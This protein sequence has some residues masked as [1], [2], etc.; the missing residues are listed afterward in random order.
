VNVDSRRSGCRRR[1]NA[2]S[3]ACCDSSLYRIHATA[4]SSGHQSSSNRSALV[5][6]CSSA[7]DVSLVSGPL[8]ALL[9]H[10]VRSVADAIG[11]A[12]SN[13]A[14]VLPSDEAVR[15]PP[16]C[17]MIMRQIASP[18]P[19]PWDLVV[20]NAVK[21]RSNF[22]GSIP[23]PESYIATATAS[24]L[25]TCVVSRSTRFRSTV[26]SIASIAL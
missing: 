5:A 23:A 20:T 3:A 21:M 17:S 24:E 13:K 26:A 16:C 11:T 18:N 9:T 4:A 12:N 14:P 7:V 10:L 25:R 1:A 15:W 22:S 8:G 19:M 6:L 2:N